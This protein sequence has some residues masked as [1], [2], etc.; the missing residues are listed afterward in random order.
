VSHT[1]LLSCAGTGQGH[2]PTGSELGQTF[3]A[4]EQG[5][6]RGYCVS[7]ET[8][9]QANVIDFDSVQG[10]RRVHA[11]ECSRWNSVSNWIDRIIE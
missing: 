10:F 3:T 2:Q 8:L 9:K 4:I 5:T 6:G 7:G 1:G 11:Q